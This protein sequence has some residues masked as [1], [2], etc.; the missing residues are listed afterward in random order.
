VVA[1]LSGRVTSVQV[2]EGSRVEPTVPALSIVPE[3]SHYEATIFVPNKA[4]GEIKV[5]QRVSLMYDA[6]PFKRY[7][8]F[9]ATIYEIAEHPLSPAEINSSVKQE[10]PVYRVKARLKDQYIRSS[11]GNRAL[12][13]GM[14]FRASIRLD[15]KTLMSRI[16]EPLATLSSRI[17]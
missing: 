12:R 14:T 10:V 16:F 8:S 2:T 9:E 1:P 6:F 3:S 15:E 4:I 7:G 5:G 17:Q 13:N 11:R